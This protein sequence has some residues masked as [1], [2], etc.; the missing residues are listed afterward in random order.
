LVDDELRVTTNIK[1]LNP[2]LGGDAHVVDECLVFC[3]IV[4]C[5]EVQSNHIEESISLRRDQYY[6]SPG[7]VEGERAIKI[8]APVLLGDQGGY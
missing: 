6:T 1:S 8:H 5:T 4:G 2:K 3:H 7:P